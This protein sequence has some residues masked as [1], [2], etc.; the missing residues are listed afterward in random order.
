MTRHALAV[1]LAVLTTHAATARADRLSFEV[2]AGAGEFTDGH[3][4]AQYGPTMSLGLGIA[5]SRQFAF[6]LRYVRV[7]EFGSTRPAT[8]H[9]ALGVSVV[10]FSGERLFLGL[11]L[12]FGGAS[13]PGPALSGRIGTVLSPTP[14]GYFFGSIELLASAAIDGDSESSRSAVLLFGYRGR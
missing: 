11:G 9:V 4:D 10:A 13:S 3:K 14:G 2:G 8:R 7:Q 5:T 12:G 1:A 6:D